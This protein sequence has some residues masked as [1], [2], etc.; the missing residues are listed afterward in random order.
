M[1]TG[2]QPLPAG[3]IR[4]AARTMRA[5]ARAALSES[6][7]ALRM[8]RGAAIRHE[9][10]LEV[11]LDCLYALACR[12]DPSA[13]SHGGGCGDGGCGD[14]GGGDGNGRDGGGGNYTSDMETCDARCGGCVAEAGCT[15]TPPGAWSPANSPRRPNTPDAGPREPSPDPAHLP[16]SRRSLA[17]VV[18]VTA[19]FKA[20]ASA[21]TAQPLYSCRISAA[22]APSIVRALARL[23]VS[24]RQARIG[25]GRGGKDNVGQHWSQDDHLHKIVQELPS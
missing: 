19:T 3:R 18:G 22:P 15:A 20:V 11:L 6:N 23:G 9:D 1:A 7:R 24:A 4:S 21:R 2:R 10:R 12:G 25:E 13:P 17:T 14:G 5:E 16:G 8:L